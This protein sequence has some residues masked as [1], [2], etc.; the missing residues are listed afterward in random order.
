MTE[1]YELMRAARRAREAVLAP[2]APAFPT[3][4]IDD[5]SEKPKRRRRVVPEHLNKYPV[6]VVII[7]MAIYDRRPKYRSIKMFVELN[8]E[9]QKVLIADAQAVLNALGGQG[10]TVRKGK[11]DGSV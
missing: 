10:Y 5:A 9:T 2:S 6:H 11:P 4:K 1:A 8:I 3:P 7:A